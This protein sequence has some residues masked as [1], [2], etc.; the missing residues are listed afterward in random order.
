MTP[1]VTGQWILP[2]C[3]SGVEAVH[4]DKAEVPFSW[5]AVSAAEQAQGRKWDSLFE[6]LY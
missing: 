5:L 1:L 4:Q 2:S 3:H 6:D